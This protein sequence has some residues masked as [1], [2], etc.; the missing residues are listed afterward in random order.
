M[1]GYY[2]RRERKGEMIWRWLGTDETQAINRGQALLDS[3][4]RTPT[5]IDRDVLRRLF[6]GTLR[7]AKSRGTPH[8]LT[9]EDVLAIAER[10]GG[11]CEISHMPFD[12][13]PVRG[14][15]QRRPWCPSIDRIDSELGYTPEN[16]RLV[17]CA[18]NLAMNK[19]GYDVLEQLALS[20]IAYRAK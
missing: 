7:N 16:C 17:T 11:Y 12:C 1:G 5:I 18:A 8:S 20:I 2:F 9:F 15:G 13:S 4:D 19:W 3:L 14:K 6:Y 10:S